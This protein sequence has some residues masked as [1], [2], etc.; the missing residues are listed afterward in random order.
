MSQLDDAMTALKNADAAGDHE[1]AQRLAAIA[2]Q[3]RQQ[4]APQ[5]S[6]AQPS[7]QPSQPAKPKTASERAKDAIANI[8][9]ASPLNHLAADD[10]PVPA[11]T[12]A[13]AAKSIAGSTA[14]GGIAGALSP[15]IVTG[16]GMAASFL[17]VVGEAV[18]PALMETGTA[19]RGAR[20]AEAGLGA[21]SGLTSE[22]AGQ[23]VE[24]SG[25]TK[26]Q[27]EGARLV[28]GML[29]PSAGAVAGYV[30]KPA[31]LA[32][33]L[34][35]KAVG[36][37]Q[38]IPKAVAAARENMAKLSEAGQPQTA[39][40]AML[41]KGV[42]ADRQAADKAAD[43]V[44]ADAH[45]RAGA[46][47]QSDAAT[48]TRLV[49]AART[50]ADQIRAE[51]AQRANV[52]DKASAG[53]TATATR[54]LAQA[55][56][57]LAKVGQVSELSD[58]GNTLRQAATAKQ[59]EEIA[60]RNAAYQ[61][62]V[63][64]RDAAVKAKEEAGQHVGETA[65]LAGLKKELKGKL[66]G[67]GGFAKTTDA[68]VRRVYQ[69]VNDALNPANQ[70]LSFEALDQ[71]R[72]RLG[73]VIA[74]NQT[75]EGYEAIGKQAAQKMYAQISKAQEQFV[76]ENAAKENVQRKLQ[77]EYYEASGDLT[78]FG[79]KVGKKLTAVDRIDP[80]KFAGDAKA[81]PKAFFN[82]QQ[83]V[84]DAKELTGNPQL[85]D[86]Q[87]AD[88]AARSMQGMSAKQAQAWAR[89]NHDWM[90]EVPGLSQRAN[91]YADKLAQ[92]ERVNEGLSKRAA[93]KAKEAE[94]TRGGA[95]VAAERERQTGLVE[96]GR[97]ARGTEEAK[98]R[99]I[100]EGSKAASAA[101][102]QEFAPAKGLETI[103]K[104]GEA[105]EAIR[106][107]LLNGKPEQTR[108]AARALAN[109]PG[110]KQVLEQSV[111]QSMRNMTEGNL[112]QQWTERI[113]PMLSDG[114]MIPP[115]RLKALDED[116]NRLLRAY[117]GPDKLS[118]VQRHIAAAIGTV[119]GQIPNQ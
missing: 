31:K 38:D 108:L 5:Q 106:N 98:Q 21:V 29:T 24:A 103:L 53:K 33:G 28:G 109:E 115:E 45:K 63:A 27:A 25:G 116:V 77:S 75:V 90:R 20:L 46:I 91:S 64:E 11:P 118:M 83:S 102:E 22:A 44:M 73:D 100:G 111:R 32:W 62:T 4:Q 1:A 57:E 113:R 19:M 13:S 81:L 51:A 107:L 105:P 110:G 42:E 55:A 35:Q 16:L 36:A 67:E 112:R 30:A 34:L 23:A 76:G 8:N 17:P 56:P 79:S 65:A 37:E 92:I 68:G 82:S 12:I 80:E 96:A 72:R 15:E 85:V 70:K 10:K 86:R 97:V 71:V 9:A 26:A 74:G 69:Q 18:G 6:A 14:F 52:L 61:A 78:R 117:K 104:G 47:A 87:A 119:G 40:H 89:D 43:A 54:V 88:Y 66:E 41:Q 49:D 95:A 2:D 3:L 7:A 58:I 84:R 93:L 39:M 101:R 94:A 50:R 99:V 48:A 59:G 60:A 114:K